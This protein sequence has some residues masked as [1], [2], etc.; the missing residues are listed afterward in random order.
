MVIS[1][2][3]VNAVKKLLEEDVN[4]PFCVSMKWI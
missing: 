4:I 1:I 3:L 2:L